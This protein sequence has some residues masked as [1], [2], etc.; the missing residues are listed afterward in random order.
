MSSGALRVHALFVGLICK[1]ACCSLCM[2]L[3][4]RRPI[5]CP[6]L[7]EEDEGTMAQLIEIAKALPGHRV[8]SKFLHPEGNFFATR[9]MLFLFK[10]KG[11]A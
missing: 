9:M 8:S 10:R 6:A 4:A 1:P 5:P 7:S 11:W 2:M 3:G